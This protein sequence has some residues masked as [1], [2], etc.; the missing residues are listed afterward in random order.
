MRKLLLAGAAAMLVACETPEMAKYE[1]TVG[2]QKADAQVYFLDGAVE[3]YHVLFPNDSRIAAASGLMGI[4]DNSNGFPDVIRMS[5]RCKTG[6][7]GLTEN[8]EHETTYEKRDNKWFHMINASKKCELPDN[9]QTVAN[10]VE[11][12]VRR[13]VSK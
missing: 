10:E 3:T 12:A 11:E 6:Y 1:I 13:T 8:G 7:V 5:V 2:G 9:A 4:D